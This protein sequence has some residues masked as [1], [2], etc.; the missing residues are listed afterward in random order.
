MYLNGP[1][2]FGKFNKRIIY[3]NVFLPEL[4]DKED[5]FNRLGEISDLA[6]NKLQVKMIST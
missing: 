6:W 3:I 5:C 1:E 4:Y 2:I